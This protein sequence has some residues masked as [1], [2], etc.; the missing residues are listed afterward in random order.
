[1]KPAIPCRFLDLPAEIRLIIYEYV[2]VLNKPIEVWPESGTLMPA[3]D[4]GDIVE[5]H[6]LIQ[7]R[8]LPVGM[9][10]T[11][12]LVQQEA[13]P[14]FYGTIRFRFSGINGTSVACVF[15]NSTR[16]W[17]N[18]HLKSITIPMPF[19]SVAP[20]HELMSMTPWSIPKDLRDYGRAVVHL[21]YALSRTEL[22]KLELVLPEWYEYDGETY[23]DQ[24]M[25]WKGLKSLAASKVS[26]ES[27]LMIDIVYLCNEQSNGEV[28][29]LQENIDL[30][31]PLR[32]ELPTVTLSVAHFKPKG[33]WQVDRQLDFDAPIADASN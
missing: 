28:W 26:K 2:L 12:K 22:S 10:R 32:R 19:W 21:M 13:T 9:L 31:K 1:M 16:L 5:I 30:L 27:P 17:N 11:C 18:R 6:R 23:H 14:I 7:S 4:R 3:F 24:D 20:E 33:A 15:L 25:I 29:F 8:E